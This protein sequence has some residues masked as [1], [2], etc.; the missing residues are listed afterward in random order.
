MREGE[1]INIQYGAFDNIVCGRFDLFQHDA[2]EVEQG[3]QSKAQ[4]SAVWLPPANP[5]I[6]SKTCKEKKI[7]KMPA[8]ESSENRL[9][10][11]FG[12]SQ[13]VTG[14][15]PKGLGEWSQE[16]S[17]KGNMIVIGKIILLV[18]V[19][20]T[21]VMVN[22][23]NIVTT[24]KI[25]LVDILYP[26]LEIADINTKA[27]WWFL[28]WFNNRIQCYHTEGL[29]LLN[30]FNLKWCSEGIIARDR[31]APVIWETTHDP[32]MLE[33]YCRNRDITWGLTVYC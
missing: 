20:L 31:I 5:Q 10:F 11:V 2:V 28:N 12:V 22:L 9:S 21:M 18:L 8:L 27:R 1:M 13:C 7:N 32:L 26:N 6:S 24:R 29:Q 3:R 19:F 14:T 33:G 23:R 25:P 16:K 30:Q 15:A 4:R 17:M